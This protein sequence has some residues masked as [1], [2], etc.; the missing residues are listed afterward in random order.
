M[1]RIELTIDVN[2]LS[3]IEKD[4]DSGWG[5]WEG[6]REI[7]QNGVDAQTEYNAPLTIDWYNDT[8]R[9]CN[10]GCVLPHEAL[11]LGYS[12]K[13]ERQDLI[14][15]WGEGL[16]LGI[17][18]L[19]RAGHEVKIR[20]GSEVWVPSIVD[21]DKFKARVL[22]FD[23]AGGRKDEQRVR[24]EIG[25]I[26]KNEWLEIKERFLFLL[27]RKQEEYVVA[28]YNGELLI[29][30]KYKGRLYV[31]G[32]FVEYKHDLAFG[33]NFYNANTDRDRKMVEEWDFRYHAKNI[34]FSAS[35]DRI[36]VLNAVML[37]LEQQ[38][39]DLA[40]VDEYNAK[41]VPTEI[42]EHAAKKFV[43]QFGEHAVP[44]ANVGESKDIEHFGKVGVVVPKG[45]KLVLS[46][47]LG[48][49]DDVK[50]KLAKSAIRSFGWSD[51][52]TTQQKNLEDAM[53]LLSTA[54][55][56]ASLHDVDVVDFHNGELLG[57]FVNGRVLIARRMLDDTM[58]ALRVLVHE[59]AHR[60]GGDGDKGHVESL[61]LIWKSIVKG[62]WK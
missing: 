47:K 33:Y 60:G 2:Y 52:T 35:R 36:D 9:I 11:L 58:D 21:S 23:I 16:K 3:N 26:T 12:S 28:P 25:G 30:D 34:L 48:S 54:I 45:L 4:N 6:L 7:V 56:D 10:E 20:S 51:L 59:Y 29:G 37:G 18:A 15:K 22:A 38:K 5:L 27:N 14:G 39:P 61:E 24:I 19:V 42:V 13:R 46:Q 62:I 44:V 50:E 8:V 43:E 17:L 53:F 55:P 49:F 40:G 32:I 57:Q 41:S 31:K 1:P